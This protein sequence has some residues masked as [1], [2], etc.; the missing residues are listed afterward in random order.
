[1]SSKYDYIS[2]TYI[3]NYI[4]IYDIGPILIMCGP[5]SSSSTMEAFSSRIYE[6]FV[7]EFLDIFEEMFLWY[8]I[9]SS[10]YVARSSLK[11]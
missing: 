3:L 1:M 7:S 4:M 6:T 8:H 9:H 5:T 11:L 10:M 2:S